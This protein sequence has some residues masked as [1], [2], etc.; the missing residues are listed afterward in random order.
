MALFNLNMATRVPMTLEGHRALNE[1]LHRL[2]SVDR[3]AI[4][5]AVEEARSHGD[6]RENAEYHAAKEKYGFI[7]GRIDEL[8]EKLATAEVVDPTHLSGEKVV[9][10]ATVQLEDVDSGDKV[11]YQIVG[12]DEADIKKS[13]INYQS[14]IARAIIGKVVDDEVEVKIPKGAV[15][16]QILKV[17]FK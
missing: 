11:V 9:F 1:E 3:P 10:G 6:L 12:E 7:Q 13:K 15:T 17:E 16:Y 14:P 5:L 4:I 2:K 8:A